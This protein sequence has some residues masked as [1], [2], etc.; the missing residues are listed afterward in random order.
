M[1]V[2]DT[3]TLTTGNRTQRRERED[4]EIHLSTC[5]RVYRK[6]RRRMGCRQEKMWAA[7]V[8][9]CRSK[10][11]RKTSPELAA[12]LRKQFGLKKGRKPEFEKKKKK[13]N[14]A[15]KLSNLTSPPL[16][17]DCAQFATVCVRPFDQLF[18]CCR[19]WISYICLRMSSSMCGGDLNVRTACM[20]VGRRAVIERLSY[21][22]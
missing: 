12:G 9:Y 11:G 17:F 18:C 20:H 16:L 15:A 21:T 14:T 10:S 8:H 2:V 1:T 5:R 22:V 6:C 3:F 19:G 4:V 7:A 13:K